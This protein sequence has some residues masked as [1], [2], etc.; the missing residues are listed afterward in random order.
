MLFNIEYTAQSY[1]KISIGKTSGFVTTLLYYSSFPA[2]P[3]SA[4]K[5]LWNFY[6]N[7]KTHNYLNGVTK[8]TEEKKE[9]MKTTRIIHRR[10]T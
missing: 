5:M 4:Q 1:L 3:S 8:R 6:Y 2:G 10:C 7:I 9:M